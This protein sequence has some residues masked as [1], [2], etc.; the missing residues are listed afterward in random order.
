MSAPLGNELGAVYVLTGPDG[1]RAVLNDSTDPDCVGFIGR[2]TGQVTGLER[3]GVREA[4]DV[5]PGLSGGVHGR[6]LYDRLPFTIGATIP[7]DYPGGT[8]QERQDRIM[9]A[10]DAMD[11]D[12]L[13]QWTPAE[14]PPVQVAYR[15]QQPTRL[16]GARPK[17]VLI[18]GVSADP[19]VYSQTLHQV[20]APVDPTADP[21]T[22]SHADLVGTTVG[23]SAMSWPTF[24]V[25][26]PI[27]GSISGIVADI[28]IGGV[29]APAL[30]WLT[31]SA[32]GGLV[33]ASNDLLV[34]DFHPVRRSV[35]VHTNSGATL[36]RYSRR[37]RS[38]SQWIPL[39][40]GDFAIRL[41]G[42]VASGAGGQA[43][44]T[45]RDAWG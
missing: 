34:V 21:I 8:W 12:G 42:A 3:A 6:F 31:L 36:N 7:P 28:L 45:W 44:L 41:S 5:L 2:D 35:L 43:T 9:R 30:P 33:L 15:Q 1:T 38:T 24:T 20:T 26:A 4:A 17:S 39:P 40:R 27:G 10:T 32:N 19:C 14:A 22:G 11:A 23:R 25:Q 16:S 18:T 13:L 37:N 29:V